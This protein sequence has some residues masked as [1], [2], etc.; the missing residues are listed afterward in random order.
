M[1]NGLKGMK[2]L[3]SEQY[4][5]PFDSEQSACTDVKRLK[6][7]NLVQKHDKLA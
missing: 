1:K 7:D 5:A 2:A 4:A 6:S 3:S